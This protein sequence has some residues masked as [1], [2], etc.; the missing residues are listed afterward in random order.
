MKLFK[1]P[2]KAR[3]TSYANS[4]LRANNYFQTMYRFAAVA[5]WRNNTKT[6]SKVPRVEIPKL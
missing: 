2:V 4:I 6:K 5:N 3:K 1:P